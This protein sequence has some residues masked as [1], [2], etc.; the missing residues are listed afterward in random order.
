MKP[1]VQSSSD[2]GPFQ[3]KWPEGPPERFR[4]GQDLVVAYAGGRHRVRVGVGSHHVY[5]R[6]RVHLV[7]WVNGSPTVEGVEADDY[8]RSASL[9]S[10]IKLGTKKRVWERNEIPSGYDAYHV[11]VHRDEI[12]APYSPS[13]LAVKIREDRTTE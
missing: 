3:Y 2:V 6:Q 11:V 8:V 9:L 10:L 13:S 5:G 7:V 1:N 4:R 12:D